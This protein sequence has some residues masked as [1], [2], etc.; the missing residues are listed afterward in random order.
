MNLPMKSA[1]TTFDNYRKK[2][3]IAEKLCNLNQDSKKSTKKQQFPSVYKLI[4]LVM[5]INVY[6]INSH[7]EDSLDPVQMLQQL[8]LIWYQGHCF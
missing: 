2:T 6:I 7:V 8:H 3:I 1:C 5:Y 4:M